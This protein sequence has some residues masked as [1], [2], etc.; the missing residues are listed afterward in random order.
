MWEGVGECGRVWKGA[1]GW[2][3]V[4]GRMGGRVREEESGWWM[5]SVAHSDEAFELAAHPHGVTVRL[6]EA[7]GGL[8]GGVVCHP[9]G[10][11]R[12]VQLEAASAKVPESTA[13]M[14]WVPMLGE[15]CRKEVGWWWR[16]VG[17]TSNDWE[18]AMNN[19]GGDRHEAERKVGT[20]LGDRGLVVVW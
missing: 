17:W 13:D 14:V 12:L 4:G 8:N 9:R 1:G 19:T 5:A 2:D 7:D 18:T 10:R 6:D 11:S 15:V 20:R 3:C 16:E